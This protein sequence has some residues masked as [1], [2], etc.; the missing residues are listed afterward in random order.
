[1][2]LFD[3][4]AVNRR[5]EV[6]S[7]T[8]VVVGCWQL[9]GGHGALS[10]SEVAHH[11]HRSLELGLTAFDCADIYTGV[12]ELLGR[13]I[14]DLRRE[15]SSM[16]SNL[17]IHTKFVPDLDS[18]ATIEKKDVEAIVDRSLRRLGVETLDLVQYHW[19]D[20]S[21]PRYVEVASYLNELRIAGKIRH[22]G[23]TNFATSEV[24]EFVGAGIPIVSNQVQYSVLDRRP[25]RELA[26]FCEAHGIKLLCYGAT[27]GGFLAARYLD[28]PEPKEPFENRSLLKYRLIIEE[29]GGWGSYQRL[30]RGLNEIAHAEGMELAELAQSFV[31]TR[32]AVGA[33]IVGTRSARHL[34]SNHRLLSERCSRAATERIEGLLAELFPVPGEVYA[35][36]RDRTGRHGSIMRYNLSRGS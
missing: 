24:R 19:W 8:P 4:R 26:P 3:N 18:L 10:E 16:L 30:L 1:M 34:E 35:L 29:C 23:L 21:V 17:R 15:G 2:N 5:T 32:P 28:A 33:V 14:G 6:F 9:A 36:E 7:T 20:L 27:A 11:L 12:E 25:E 31:L 22:L 13:F